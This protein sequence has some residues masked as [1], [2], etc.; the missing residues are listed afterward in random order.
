MWIGLASQYLG[1]SQAEQAYVRARDAAS[2]ALEIDPDLA[3]AHLARASLLLT[4]GLNWTDAKSEAQR[5]LQLAPNDAYAKFFLGGIL[6]TLEQTRRAVDLTRQ[7]L[8][9]D[10]RRW[11]L[12]SPGLIV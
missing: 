4:A 1:G 10:P 6:A 8:Q 2:A 7:A 12:I 5:A 11:R 9:A 3:L